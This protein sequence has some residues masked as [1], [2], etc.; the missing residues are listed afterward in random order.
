MFTTSMRS[1]I[2]VGLRNTSKK[3]CALV[4]KHTGCLFVC[5]FVC[6]FLSYSDRFYLL[7]LDVQFYCCTWSHSVSLSLSLSLSHTHTHTHTHT[8]L[9]RPSLEE[10][11]ARSRELC[12]TSTNIHNRQPAMSQ[13]GFEP[14]VPASERP[15][16][17]TIDRADTRIDRALFIT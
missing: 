8:T 5:L 4:C 14:A 17:Q 13:A 12:L 11:S 6:C 9:G 16:T 7:I 3:T 15:Q 2:I 10:G 1:S